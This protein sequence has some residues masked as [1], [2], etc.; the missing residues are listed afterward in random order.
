MDQWQDEARVNVLDSR[1]NTG[2]V[3]N[4]AKTKKKKRKDQPISVCGSGT[5]LLVT[6]MACGPFDGRN[7]ERERQWGSF[8]VQPC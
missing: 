6:I 3:V 7:T 8:R 2:V 5:F 1:R 4:E